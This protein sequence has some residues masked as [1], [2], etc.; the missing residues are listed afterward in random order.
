MRKSTQALLWSAVIFPG[1]GHLFLKSFARGIALIAIS[2]ISLSLLLIQIVQYASQVIEKALAGGI[3]L[4]LQY[5]VATTIQASADD[6]LIN[7]ALWA[8][9][10][11]WLLG[12]LDAYLLGKKL[13][14]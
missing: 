9:I 5:V 6:K 4:D 13:E 14:H 12:M 2:L 1:A 10:L 7:A 3:N 11:C 8:L